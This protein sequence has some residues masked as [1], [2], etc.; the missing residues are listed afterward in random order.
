MSASE[1]QHDLLNYYHVKPVHYLIVC[2]ALSCCYRSERILAGPSFT[3][4]VV[5]FYRQKGHGFVQPSDGSEP[6]FMHISESVF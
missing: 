3:G 5:S 2:K 1:L 4:K 6:L